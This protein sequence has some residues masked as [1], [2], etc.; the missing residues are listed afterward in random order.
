MIL[1]RELWLK[2]WIVLPFMPIGIK[3]ILVT[4]KV[5]LKFQF[6]IAYWSKLIHQQSSPAPASRGS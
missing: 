5:T 2:K 3:T 4:E 6:I 1:Q